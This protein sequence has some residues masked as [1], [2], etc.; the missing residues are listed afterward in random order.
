MKAVDV[1][2]EHYRVFWET[3]LANLKTFVEAEYAKESAP[4]RAKHK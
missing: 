3:S 1:W 4:D 2:L